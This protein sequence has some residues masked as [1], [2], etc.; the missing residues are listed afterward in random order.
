VK[1]VACWSKKAA[2]SLQRVNIEEKLL[3]RVYRKSQTLFRTVPSPIPYSLPFPKFGGL[4]PRPK[5]AIVII[6][7]T[8]KATDCK[9]G[10]YIYNLSIRAQA[11]EKF[12]RK[13]ECGRI[14]GLP[15]FFEYPLLSQ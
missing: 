5:T 12:W 13:K 14:Q 3:W 4:Q 2:I 10:L 15:K 8:A 11:R 9:F 7:G 1:K 6:S